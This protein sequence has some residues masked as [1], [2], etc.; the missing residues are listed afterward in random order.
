[1]GTKKTLSRVPISDGVDFRFSI[2]FSRIM[3]TR[4]TKVSENVDKFTVKYSSLLSTGQSSYTSAKQN[5]KAK[6][7]RKRKRKR[8]TNPPLTIHMTLPETAPPARPRPQT[9]NSQ[10]SNYRLIQ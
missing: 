5:T 6:A 10:L 1:M 9:P 4:S 3:Y 2:C 8:T 7:K